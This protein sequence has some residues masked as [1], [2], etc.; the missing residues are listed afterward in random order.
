VD[1]GGGSGDVAALIPFVRVPISQL[2]PDTAISAGTALAAIK[3]AGA[4]CDAV[5]KVGGSGG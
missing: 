2:D 5:D 4:V 3:A 1:E